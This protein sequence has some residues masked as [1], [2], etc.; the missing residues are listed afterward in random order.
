MKQPKITNFFCP[1]IKKNNNRKFINH[2]LKPKLF[3]HKILKP[4]PLKTKRL[5]MKHN[6][7][8]HNVDEGY[9]GDDENYIFEEKNY[10]VFNLLNDLKYLKINL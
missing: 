10:K 8:N 6:N 7:L 9:L 3:K 1:I 5:K 2:I 4:K